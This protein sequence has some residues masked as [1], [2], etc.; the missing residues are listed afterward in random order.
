MYD[1]S[2]A[3]AVCAHGIH[4]S[5][6]YGKRRPPAAAGHGR[7]HRRGL[8]QGFLSQEQIESS[9]LIMGI[10]S[11]L[12]EDGTYFVVEDDSQV[13]VLRWLEPAGDPLRK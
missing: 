12:I 6:R 7:R 10:D 1:V 3:A 2:P 4:H 13:A 8:K 9:R 11:Q 5:R